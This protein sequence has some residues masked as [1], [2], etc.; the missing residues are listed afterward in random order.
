MG[1]TPG[2]ALLICANDLFLEAM[3]PAGPT[4]ALHCW[5]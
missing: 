3:A 5:L 4:S 1:L 2:P